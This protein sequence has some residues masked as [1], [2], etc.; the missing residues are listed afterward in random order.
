M[1]TNN[2]LCK[3]KSGRRL[4]KEYRR[5]YRDVEMVTFG[6]GVGGGKRTL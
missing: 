6:S 2:P 4:M 5:R 1:F 3:K